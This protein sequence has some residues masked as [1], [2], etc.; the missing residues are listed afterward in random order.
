MGDKFTAEQATKFWTNNKEIRDGN[1]P[2]YYAMHIW[3]SFWLVDIMH[4]RVPGATQIVEIGSGIG[5][6]LCI[7]EKSGYKR[8]TGIEPSKQSIEI[9]ELIYPSKW[10]TI[11]ETVQDCIKVVPA[12]CYISMACLQHVHPEYDW[13]FKYIAKAKYLVL[14]E[15]ERGTDGYD[16][17]YPRNYKDLF[18]DHEVIHEEQVFLDKSQMYMA[19][20]YRKGGK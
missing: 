5:R 11:N 12:E 17:I 18:P 2:S 19:R 9:G 6:N 4:D 1:H 16:F 14:I 3:R 8:L 7:L 13:V 10:E 15:M 20:V